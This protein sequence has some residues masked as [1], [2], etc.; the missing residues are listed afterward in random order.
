MQLRPSS[1][2][3]ASL[4]SS[5]VA[6]LLTAVLMFAGAAFAATETVVYSFQG[7]PDGASPQASLVADSAGNLYGTTKLG[8]SSYGTVFELSPPATSGGAWT[9]SI[10][11][12]F[13][14]APNDGAFPI[15]TLVFDKQGNLYGTTQQ[16]GLGGAGTGTI[17][18]LTPPATTGGA[19]TETILWTFPPDLLKGYAPAGKLEMDAAGNLYGTTQFGGANVNACTACGV[20]FELI[21]PKTSGQSWSERVLYNFG[22]VANDGMTPAPDVLLR[23]G[24]LYGTTQSGGTAKSGTIFQLTPKSGFW[25]ETILHNFIDSE[26]IVPLGGLVADA[27]GNLFGTTTA[28]G[29]RSICSCG[30]VYELS[31]P[32]VSGRTWQEKTLYAFVGL[33]DGSRPFGSLWLDSRGNLYGTATIRGIKHFEGFGTVFKLNAPAVSGGAWTLSVLHDFGGFGAGDGVFPLGGVILLNGSF[34]GTAMS[35]GTGSGSN[36]SGVV[37]SVTP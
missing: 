31:P 37:F 9:E 23:G 32:A 34:C 10:L 12:A 16:G 13:Q 25:T 1:L 33:T 26:G 3:Q 7:S 11:Y 30:T 21:K 15:G 27:S 2:I 35:G 36:G 14:N 28:G 19:W 20:V 24:V 4:I 5:R 6:F 17:F 8:G 18:E 29:N 22:T